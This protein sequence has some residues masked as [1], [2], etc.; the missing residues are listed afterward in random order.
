MRAGLENGGVVWAGGKKSKLA[1][2]R[3]MEL[4]TAEGAGEEMVTE[5]TTAPVTSV[6]VSRMVVSVW[7]GV[8]D[9]SG[10]NDRANGGW[11]QLSLSKK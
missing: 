6:V 3:Q 1:N 4:V 9:V 5:T 8:P 2:G 10:A 7:R 11:S